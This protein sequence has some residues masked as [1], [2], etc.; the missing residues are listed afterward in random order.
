MLDAKLTTCLDGPRE[1]RSSI[2][3]MSGVTRRP[4]A[5][6]VCV[7]KHSRSH[8]G[9]RVMPDIVSRRFVRPFTGLQRVSPRT[10]NGTRSTGR[11]LKVSPIRP[12]W[13]GRGT[14]QCGQ[15]L[16]ALP[17]DGRNDGGHS[18]QGSP[19]VNYAITHDLASIGALRLRECG[20]AKP[21]PKAGDRMDAVLRLG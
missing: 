3:L 18:H 1:R 13:R 8:I 14:K 21:R 7:H 12:S 19:A 20:F 15:W 17:R 4:F 2:E 10:K 9:A 5:G 16:T 11:A 6:L